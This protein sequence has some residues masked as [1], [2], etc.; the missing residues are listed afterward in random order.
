MDRDLKELLSAL[1]ARD[2]KYVVV[3]GYAVGVHAQPR[4]TKDIDIF[5]EMSESNATAVYAA[6]ADFGAPLT[7]AHISRPNR[8]STDLHRHPSAD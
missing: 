7:E 5:I 6:L 2:A 3:G 1:N 4:I 8:R